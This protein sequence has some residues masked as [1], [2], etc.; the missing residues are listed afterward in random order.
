MAT[1]NPLT[2]ERI[3]EAALALIDGTGIEKFTMRALGQQLGVDPMAIY[4]HLP[5]KEAVFDAVIEMLWR[6]VADADRHDD[7]QD[8]ETFLFMR[9]CAV[10]TRLLAHPRAVLLL[11]TRPAT[12]PT[13]LILLEQMLAQMHSAALPAHEAMLLV[14]CLAAYT[15]GK[16]L[17]EVSQMQQQ[18]KVAAAIQS[19]TPHSHP[20]LMQALGAGY[21]FSPEAQFE[22]GLRAL[23]DGWQAPQAARKSPI[24]RPRKK[25]D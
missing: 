18:D 2:R 7:G 15:V 5:N 4:H 1:R 10:R 12:T 14:D 8:W 22:R 17:G 11:G 25:A 9:F 3:A 13:L 19:L 20:H 23:L 6:E 24:P 21:D 16:V